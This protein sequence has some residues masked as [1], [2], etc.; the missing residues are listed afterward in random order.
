MCLL[1]S[2]GISMTRPRTWG[3]TLIT[4]LSTRTSFDEGANTLRRRTSAVRP[5]IGIVITITC[6]TVFHGSHLNL[7]KISQTKNE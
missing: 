2:A 5:M 7:K 3:T 4:Y 6:E 1:P